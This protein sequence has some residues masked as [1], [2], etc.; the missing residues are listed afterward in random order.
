MRGQPAMK[1]CAFFRRQPERR[2][3]HI[4]RDAVPDFL[5]EFNALRDVERAIVACCSVHGTRLHHS[6]PTR[7]AKSLANP[8]TRE[9]APV[10]AVRCAGSRTVGILPASS[11]KAGRTERPWTRASAQPGISTP[12]P[13]F[14]RRDL[15]LA[16]PFVP[17][18][19][20]LAWV[21]HRENQYEVPFVSV[22]HAMRKSFKWPAAYFVRQS[23][24]R[25]R[26]A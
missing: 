8:R 26:L 19:R 22:K 15:L 14:R 1:F 2:R 23:L 24:H 9:P 18:L 20:R 21:K 7:L 5:D 3:R 25:Q 17:S 10:R 11:R 16:N 12:A 6:G 4:L 13:Q